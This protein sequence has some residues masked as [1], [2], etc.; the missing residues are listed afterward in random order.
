[1]KNNDNKFLAE[2][3]KVALTGIEKGGGPFGA[4]IVRNGELIAGSFNKV[5]L[6]NDPTAHAEVLA[7][8]EASARMGTH[9][10]SDCT[11]YTSCE[12]CPMCLGAIYWA[13]IKKVFYSCDKYDAENSGFSDK[14]IYDELALDPSERKISFVKMDDAEGM[15]VFRKWDELEGKIPY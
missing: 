6:N 3:V 5:V 4:V 12:P 11:L 13:G 8:R 1:M 9:D 14:Q 15:E 7:I 2:A 10:L